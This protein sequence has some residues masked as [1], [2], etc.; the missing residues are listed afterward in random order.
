MEYTSSFREDIGLLFILFGPKYHGAAGN[1]SIAQEAEKL[2]FIQRDRLRHVVID[3]SKVVEADLRNSDRAKLGLLIQRLD[4]L[5]VCVSEFSVCVVA[6]HPMIAERYERQKGPVG[7]RLL[8][9]ETFEEAEH[10]LGMEP[11]TL[12]EMISMSNGS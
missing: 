2:P 11:G 6:T 5:G 8:L 4:R 9:V 7:F 3:C 1:E 12:E 10:M